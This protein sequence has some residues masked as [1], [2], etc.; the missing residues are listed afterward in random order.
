M[1]LLEPEFKGLTMSEYSSITAEIEKAS[2]GSSGITEDRKNIPSGHIPH[3]LLIPNLFI[4]LIN[5]FIS[6]FSFKELRVA[7]IIVLSSILSS[8]QLYEVVQAVT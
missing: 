4:Y 1:C 7:Y 2:S 6:P 5:T 8:Y 3:A